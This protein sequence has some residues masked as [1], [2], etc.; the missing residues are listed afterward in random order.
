MAKE[1]PYITWAKSVPSQGINLAGSGVPPCPPALLGPPEVE[2]PYSERGDYGWPPLRARLAA[3]YAVDPASVVVAAG[4]SMANHLA[5]ATV[6]ERGDHV[7]VEHPGYDPLVLVPELW[8]ATVSS[9]DRPA[10]D[11]Y[12]IDL[13]AIRS[14][15]RPRTRLLVL[16]NLHNPTGAFIQE[17]D[18][19]ALAALA[20]EHGFYVL[21][22]EV[23]LEWLHDSGVPSSATISPQ[24]IA[25]SSLTKVFGLSGLRIGWILAE[26]SLADRMRRFSGLFDNIVAHPSERLAVRAL[27]RSQAIIGPS[28][29][30]VARNHGHLRDW[31]AA[32]PDVC[33]IEP[34]AGT[35]AFVDLGLGDA[36]DFV[37][38][39]ARERSTLVV[40]GRFFGVPSHV[41]IGLG[42]DSEML[43]SG[44]E[45]IGTQLSEYRRSGAPA[46]S[47][48]A[49][50]P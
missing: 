12:R 47:R 2:A 38:R 18:V 1:S 50:A 49:R 41:R 45:N 24:M 27:D 32:T 31:V 33:W 5:M 30:L 11:R 6:L 25:T 40:P 23:Y 17:A 13:G 4:T 36:S 26:P 14:A 48:G 22:D 42:V 9:V 7:L 29:E 16:T 10:S 39:L 8:G 20:S 44:L 46:L 19:R 34:P 43:N 15:L 3:R 35:T 28:A 21:I 37:D